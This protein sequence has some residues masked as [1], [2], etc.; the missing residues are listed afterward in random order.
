VAAGD[1]L[2]AGAG[3]AAD[4]DVAGRDH[5]VRL[6]ERGVQRGGGPGH[7]ER[8]GLADAAWALEVRGAFEDEERAAGEVAGARERRA[9]GRVGDVEQGERGLE[10]VRGD[11]GEQRRR[12]EHPQVFH[13]ARVDEGPPRREAGVVG[14]RG[15]RRPRCDQEIVSTCTMLA[16]NT[17]MTYRTRRANVVTH[18]AVRSP[19]V[20][21]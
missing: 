1:V 15:H 13:A 17:G 4:A 3:E 12:R 19:S 21:P 9:R 18:R 11:P 2:E 6:L 5:R 14:R 10:L 16:V 8:E 20:I 7:P